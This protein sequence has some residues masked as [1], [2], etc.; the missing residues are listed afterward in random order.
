MPLVPAR[1]TVKRGPHYAS[2][3]RVGTPSLYGEPAKASQRAISPFGEKPRN[4]HG[5]S[6][7]S[8]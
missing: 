2:T 7:G 8:Y 5:H 4:D 3:F 1:T 6:K